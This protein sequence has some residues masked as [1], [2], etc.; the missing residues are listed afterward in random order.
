MWFDSW[1]EMP[2]DKLWAFSD[3]IY[4]DFRTTHTHVPCTQCV[5]HMYDPIQIALCINR[6]ELN[7][8]EIIR[9][10]NA[11]YWCSDALC[12]FVHSTINIYYNY[13]LFVFSFGRNE[14]L[15]FRY[16]FVLYFIPLQICL[17]IE[18]VQWYARDIQSYEIFQLWLIIFCCRQN[19]PKSEKWGDL[20]GNH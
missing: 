17:C 5:I 7:Q 12:L 16:G 20:C 8:S 18:L 3:F 1:L 14:L 9:L 2:F 13:F 11:I 15:S 10:C 6:N 19:M 4:S